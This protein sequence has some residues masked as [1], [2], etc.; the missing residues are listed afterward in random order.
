MLYFFVCS[1]VHSR[2]SSSLAPMASSSWGTQEHA[3]GNS[4]ILLAVVQLVRD[5]AALQVRAARL[6]GPTC[7]KR[8]AHRCHTRP[9]IL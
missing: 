2:S 7:N 9:S 4:A 3:P 8:G 6:W 1:S 5:R